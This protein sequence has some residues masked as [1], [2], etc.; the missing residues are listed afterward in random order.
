MV[1][2]LGLSVS[3]RGSIRVMDGP[4]ARGVSAAGASGS[5]STVGVATTSGSGERN[6]SS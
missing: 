3:L 1:T 6:P 2:T 5:G 4:D